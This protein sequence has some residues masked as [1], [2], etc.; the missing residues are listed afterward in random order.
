MAELLFSS[1]NI[2]PEPFLKFFLCGVLFLE[3]VCLKRLLFQR[4][5]KYIKNGLIISP[6][7]HFVLE[8]LRL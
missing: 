4:I 6:I 5:L 2:F 3:K 7:S 1:S 8:I